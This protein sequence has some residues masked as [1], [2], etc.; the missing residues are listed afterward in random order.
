MSQVRKLFA[1][2]LALSLPLAALAQ[3]STPPAPAPEQKAEAKPAEKKAEGVTVKPYGFVLANLFW[4]TE[5]FTVRDYPGQVAR[6]QSMGG[7][8]LASARQSRFGVRLNVNEENWTGAALTGVVEF[9]FNGGHIPTAFATA[10]TDDG[11]ATTP[12]VCLTTGTAPSTSWYNGI[13][14]LRLA[15][16]TATWKTAAGA[17]SV[18]AGQDYGLVNPL[19]GTSLAWTASP[20]FW[21]AGNL[22]RRGP[23]LRLQYAGTAGALGYTIAG[24]AIHPADATT[25]VDF[26]A[27]NRSRQPDFEGR[28]AVSYKASPTLNGTLGVGYMYGER[29]LGTGATQVDEDV[30][31]LGVDLEAN[32]PYVLLRGE[33]YMSDGV[34]DTYNGIFTPGVR[35]RVAGEA[36]AI[37]SSGFWGQAVIKPSEKIWLTAGYGIGSA[38]EDDLDDA[39]FTPV[40]L[41]LIRKDNEQIAAGVIVNAGKAWKVGLEAM[42]TTTTYADDTERDAFQIALS[43][44]LV[45]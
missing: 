11:N 27:G 22:W 4:D 40:A 37:A 31:L 26:G 20:I 30:S 17:F 24:A 39:G 2:L 13:M 35:V 25:P 21:Q 23:M 6:D 32:V 9:D 33:W 43:S 38:D 18:L 41:A 1:A 16:A 3:A 42:Q 45:F 7:A 14:R 36:F 34:E 5:T 10:C 19:F 12:P 29:R 8:F 28:V 15:S 44:Q